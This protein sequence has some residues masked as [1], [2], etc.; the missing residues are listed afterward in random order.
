[1]V[2]VWFVSTNR[3]K[4]EEARTVLRPYGVRLRWLRRSLP[5]PQAPD[6]ETVARAKVAALPRLRGPVLVEDSGL[7]IRS[8]HGFPGVYSAHILELWGFRPILE[9]LRHRPRSAVFRSVAALREGARIRTFAGE[10]QGS[11]ARRPA[12]HHGFGYDPIFVP[13]GYRL[14][15]G[16]LGAEVKNRLSHRARSMEAVGRHLAAGGASPVRARRRSARR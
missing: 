11:I 14:P 6:L 1:M 9:L 2:D 8:L 3:G 5:E 7:F 13:R 15:F 16:L 4:F 10:V 12:G